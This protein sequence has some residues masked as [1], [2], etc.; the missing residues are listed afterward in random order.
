MHDWDPTNIIE[1]MRSLNGG[2]HE[3]KLRHRKRRMAKPACV[4]SD[5]DSRAKSNLDITEGGMRYDVSNDHRSLRYFVLMEAEGWA[6]DRTVVLMDNLWQPRD[7]L[8]SGPRC[9]NSW[10]NIVLDLGGFDERGRGYQ[11][12]EWRRGWAEC[13][14]CAAVLGRRVYCEKCIKKT[15]R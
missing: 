3:R 5:R 8:G 9:R 15:Y 10:G 6:K 1:V 2:F 11:T 12:L 14:V 4:I 7:G 13:F